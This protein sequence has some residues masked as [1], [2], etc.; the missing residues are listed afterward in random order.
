MKIA[1]WLGKA[2]VF[3]PPDY[4]VHKIQ[5]LANCEAALSYPALSSP[6]LAAAAFVTLS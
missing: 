6:A 4:F 5:K 1:F 3:V 2:G